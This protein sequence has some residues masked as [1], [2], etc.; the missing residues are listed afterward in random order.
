MFNSA[1]WW[2]FLCGV[3]LSVHSRPVKSH[4]SYPGKRGWKIGLGWCWLLVSATGCMVASL[5]DR[6]AQETCPWRRNQDLNLAHVDFEVSVRVWRSSV[7]S[8]TPKL[9]RCKPFFR[10]LCC[11]NYVMSWSRWILRAFE[12]LALH[13]ITFPDVWDR[14]ERAAT[15]F[16]VCLCV[17]L[18]E[19]KSFFGW[20]LRLIF[21]VIA[22][23]LS[24]NVMQEGYADQVPSQG[25]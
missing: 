4:Y 16:Q 8:W 21:N 1:F 3:G 20:T 6:A 14:H 2:N 5:R 17:L 25:A 24:W 7:R 12:I 22:P 11:T 15:S 23:F 18:V 9:G 19:R 10:S 13:D